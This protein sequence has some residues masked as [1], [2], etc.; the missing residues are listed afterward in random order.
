MLTARPRLT[1]GTGYL[2]A[3]GWQLGIAATAFLAGTILQGLVVLNYPTYSPTRWQGTLIVCAVVLF[4][5]VFNISLARWL[6]I[7]EGVLLVIY[8]IGFFIINHTI[9]GVGSSR[10]RSRCVYWLLEYRWLGHNGRGGDGGLLRAD[11]LNVW[12][13]LRCAHG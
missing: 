8:F 2:V 6:P 11:Q 7:V 12:I 5:V 10:Q 3:L 9:V 13:R 1:N 4:S